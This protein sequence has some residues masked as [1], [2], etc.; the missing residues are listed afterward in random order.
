MKPVSQSR[1]LLGA[2]TK[3]LALAEW[4]LG[5]SWIKHLKISGNFLQSQTIFSHSF[6]VPYPN[7][8]AVMKIPCTLGHYALVIGFPEGEGGGGLHQAIGVRIGDVV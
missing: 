5:R 1:F 4:S 6:V 7:F 8:L 2:Q 3:M